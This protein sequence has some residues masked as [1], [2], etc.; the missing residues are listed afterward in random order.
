MEVSHFITISAQYF[1]LL[2]LNKQQEILTRAFICIPLSPVFSLRLSV[3]FRFLPASREMLCYN[4][5]IADARMPSA[6]DLQAGCSILSPELALPSGSH[7]TTTRSHGALHILGNPQPQF[8]S[9]VC[10][11]I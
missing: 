9:I 4:A 7:A 6:T 10:L 2:Q 11:V 1:A 3:G 8:F 5:V